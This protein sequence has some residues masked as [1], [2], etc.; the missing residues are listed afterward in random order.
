MTEPIEHMK[1]FD[2]RIQFNEMGINI[3]RATNE[4]EFT[5]AHELGVDT[6]LKNKPVIDTTTIPGTTIYSIFQRNDNPTFHV[7]EQNPSGCWGF[8][9]RSSLHGISRR[10]PRR[11]AANHPVTRRYA[12]KKVRRRGERG[13]SG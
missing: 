3:N 12:A 7:R 11:F 13:K 2:N 10:Y 1:H 8:A 5:D 9:R 4:V 6:S